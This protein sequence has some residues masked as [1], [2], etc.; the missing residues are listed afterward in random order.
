MIDRR[1]S[2][3]EVAE[4]PRVHSNNLVHRTM[5]MLQL[6]SG[7]SFSFLFF[8]VSFSLLLFF[9]SF[10]FSLPFLKAA[11]ISRWLRA[12]KFDTRVPHSGGNPLHKAAL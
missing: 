9:P 6:N 1:S 4:G 12:P 2:G 11:E 3:K 8:S 7:A 5:A 10:P